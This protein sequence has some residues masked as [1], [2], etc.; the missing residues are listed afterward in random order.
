MAKHVQGKV[1]TY[2][3]PNDSQDNNRPALQGASNKNPGIAVYNQHTLGGYWLVTNSNGRTRVIQQTDIGPS[4]ST[5][6]KV[7]V[8]PPAAKQL[9][10]VTTDKVVKAVY[11]GKSKAKAMLKVNG[12]K[13]GATKSKA[14]QSEPTQTSDRQV[15]LQQYLQSNPDTPSWLASRGYR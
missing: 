4:P 11:L 5:G 9:G 12:L 1:S 7:D 2:G 14:P 3:G 13:Q 10:G 6:R 15:A 8:N